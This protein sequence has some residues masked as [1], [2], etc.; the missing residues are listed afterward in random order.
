MRARGLLFGV[1]VAFAVWNIIANGV[2]VRTVAIAAMILICLA[3]NV[4]NYQQ[5]KKRRQE[6]EDKIRE[7]E[8]IRRLRAEARHKQARRGKRNKK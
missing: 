8:E 3:M 1:A 7:K 2:N 6:E 4:Y 5:K